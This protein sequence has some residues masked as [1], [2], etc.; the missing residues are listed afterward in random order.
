MARVIKIGITFDFLPDTEHSDLFEEMTES[1][2]LESAKRFFCEDIDR[3][4]KYGETYG[5]LSVEVVED[6]E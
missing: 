2:V 6:G 5:A 1:E 4:V 3:L